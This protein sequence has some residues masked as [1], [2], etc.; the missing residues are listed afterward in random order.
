MNTCENDKTERL[1]SLERIQSVVQWC[2]GLLSM[3]L[4][5]T[6][7]FMVPAVVNAVL[8]IAAGWISLVL[9]RRIRALGGRGGYYIGVKR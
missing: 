2:S 9:D 4:L 3:A 1:R 7:T 8:V 5:F 6:F